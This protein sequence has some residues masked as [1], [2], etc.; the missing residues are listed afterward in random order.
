MQHYT[1][2]ILGAQL[3]CQ[4]CIIVHELSARRFAGNDEGD[5]FMEELDGRLHGGA[6]IVVAGGFCPAD[7]DRMVHLSSIP[8]SPAATERRITSCSSE[9]FNIAAS[10]MGPASAPHFSIGRNC[11]PGR[12]DLRCSRKV[13]ATK[14]SGSKR[15]PLSFATPMRVPG[16]FKPR[17][18]ISSAT[19]FEPS[20]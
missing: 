8:F 16:R 9:L 15:L 2:A 20:P 11:S 4:L 7:K 14:P 3:L 6:V 10:S 5:A 19:D 18:L 12:A 1:R 17:P 13:A